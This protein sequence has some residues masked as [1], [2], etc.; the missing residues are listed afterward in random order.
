MLYCSVPSIYHLCSYSVVSTEV[1][2]AHAISVLTHISLYIYTHVGIWR[3]EWFSFQNFCFLYIYLPFFC[4]TFFVTIL[5]S[6]VKREKKNKVKYT[7]YCLCILVCSP[8][9][10]L[11]SYIFCVCYMTPHEKWIKPHYY[12]KEFW[13]IV[14]SDF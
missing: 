10:F 14:L 6:S 3:S 4:I 11:I 9:L 8:F 13:K 7:S 2:S 1:I 5:G 12:I